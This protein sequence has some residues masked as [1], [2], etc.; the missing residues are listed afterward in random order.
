MKT[1]FKNKL[2]Q[3]INKYCNL[4]I[5]NTKIALVLLKRLKQFHYIETL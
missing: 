3:N 1:W 5:N 4:Y 2:I